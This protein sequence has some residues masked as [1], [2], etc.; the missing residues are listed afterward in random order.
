MT[1]EKL[2]ESCLHLADLARQASTWL[3]APG[4]SDRVGPEKKS[5]LRM[6]RRS[7]RRATRLGKS[8]RT[9]MS[10]SV[11]GPSQ[12][13]KSF[14][15]SVLARPDG[16][17]LVADFGGTHLDYISALNPEGEGESTGVVTRFTTARETVPDGFPIHLTLLSE[18]DLVRVMCNSFFMDGDKSEPAPEPEQITAHINAFSARTGTAAPGIT[19]EEVIEIAEYVQG[20]FVRISSYAGALQPFWEAA[21]SIAPDLGPADRAEFF[22]ILW[23]NHAPM[24]ALYRE[25]AASLAVIDHAEDIF[26]GLDAVT[27]REASILDVKTLVNVME[28]KGA[29]I[30]V[31]TPQGRRVALP[32]ARIC[33]LA[34]E[35]VLPMLEVPHPLFAGTDL[36]DFPGARNRFDKSLGT[37]LAKPPQPS[38]ILPEL[39]LRGKVAYLFDR[40]VENQEITSMLLCVPDSNMDTVDLPRLV[41]TWIDQT[42]GNRPDLRA[43]VDCILFFILT[44]F[45]KHLSDSAAAGGDT[46]RFQRRVEASLLEKFCSGAD[47]WVESWTPGKPFANCYWLRNPNYYVDGLIDYDPA[48]RELGI[49]PK[50]IARMAELKAGC[51]ASNAVVRHFVDPA[52]A[53]DAAMALNDGGVGYLVAQLTRVC[54]P[55][56][57]LRQIEQQVTRLVNDMQCALQ[58]HCVADD[59]QIRIDERSAACVAIIDDLAEVLDRHRFGAVL[60]DLM[61]DQDQI[62]EHIS[63]V[64]SNIRIAAMTH[65]VEAPD[66]DQRPARPARPSGGGSTPRPAPP[67]DSAMTLRTMT[68]G[69]FQAET[70]LTVWIDRLKRFRDDEGLRIAYGFHAQP[71]ADLVAEL[72]HAARRTGLARRIAAHLAE[73][74]FGMTVERQAAPAAI[75]AAERI[76]DFVATLGMSALPEERRPCVT[77]EGV[78][79][80][81][82]FAARPDHATIER[83][84]ASPRRIAHEVW[85]DWVFALDA[86]VLDNAKDGVGDIDIEQNLRLGKILQGIQIEAPR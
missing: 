84:P 39:L 56:Q 13:G 71:A 7:A 14:L 76:N 3:D 17:R 54:K 60:G 74:G 36:L 16:G 27:P 38:R 19:F 50:K 37:E 85:E 68:L 83:L 59:I 24:T 8:A 80:R 21:A 44:K 82:V 26:V 78:P 18:A 72:I 61:V 73:I 31:M 79:D 46:T 47:N 48:K 4:N 2:S 20:N 11:F 53:W 23:G 69:D 81:P 33:A 34:A 25:L 67:A 86:V 35:L 12:A 40:Y 28:P 15:V 51:L 64:P 22:A 9:R 30:E 62:E 6:L 49:K 63:R 65:S 66:V 32:R 45:D 52:R 55:D 70:A 58:P 75:L 57:K 41:T 10:V 77:A 42:H 5:I 43:R 1:Q 29:T